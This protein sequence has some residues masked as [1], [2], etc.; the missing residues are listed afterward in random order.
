VRG[1]SADP[2][3]SQ[4]ARR[5]ALWATTIGLALLT[6]LFSFGLRP[7]RTGAFPIADKFG[8]GAMY[9]ATFLC[10]LLAAVWRP[11]R[12]DGPFPTKAS[13]FAFSVVMAGIVIEVLQEVATAHRH[14]EVGDVHAEGIG[15]F[16]ALAVQAWMRRAGS[17]PDNVPP[18]GP[19]CSTSAASLG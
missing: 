11:G 3:S 16:G 1:I 7:P 6:L 2:G 12:G 9:F 10:F 8:H 13:L 4:T 19:I 5:T 15:A 18:H 17:P 14:A